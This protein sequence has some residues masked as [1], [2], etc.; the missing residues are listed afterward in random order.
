MKETAATSSSGMVL[1]DRFGDRT[2][3]MAAA[4]ASSLGASTS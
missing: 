3:D 4:L 1:V 2:V